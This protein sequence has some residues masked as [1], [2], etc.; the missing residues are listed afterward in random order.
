MF[1]GSV[2]EV[3]TVTAECLGCVLVGCC[4]GACTG[5]VWCHG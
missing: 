2:R 1:F 3:L 5:G 4:F